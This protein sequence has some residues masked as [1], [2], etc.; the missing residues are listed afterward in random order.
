MMPYQKIIKCLQNAG[1]EGYLVGGCVRDHFLNKKA[2]DFD[3]TTNALPQEMKTI[4]ADYKVIETGLKHGTL[5]VLCDGEPIEVTTYRVD[6]AYSDGRHPDDVQFSSSLIEDLK[7]RDFTVNAMAMTAEGEIIDPFGGREDL[8]NRT[9]RAVGD[10][11]CRFEE[12]ALRILRAV[13][14]ASVLDFTIE[15]NTADAAIA[16]KERVGLVSKERCFSEIKK[17]LCGISIDRVLMEYPQI[18]A[19][20]L[21]EIEDTIGYN[22]NNPHHCYDLLTHT[23][24]TVKNSPPDPILRLAALFHDLGKPNTHSLDEEGIAHY[25][26]HA[27]KG[28]EIA[29]KRLEELKSDNYTKEEVL[30]LVRHHDAPAE[31][32]REQ[33]A[34][35]LRRFGSE[36][37]RKLIALR[38]ADNLAQGPEFYRTQLHDQCLIW[39]D[40]LLLEED[41]CFTLSK[42][43]VN[44]KDLMDLGYSQGP[45]IGEMLEKLLTKVSEGELPNDRETLLEYVKNAK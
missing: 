38:R 36:R 35:K 1:K 3:V 34:K 33:V 23:A 12:D 31:N 14:F 5:T 4:F 43:T 39:I 10:P 42:L 27:S 13:R 20:V 30:F 24:L 7:R 40:E 22:Q 44:G 11:F 16:L 32:D 19:T 18:F 37:L 6:G 26:G 21:P 17:A 28:T 9:I 45:V 25:Y 29:K 41:R 15:K 2:Q 8:T